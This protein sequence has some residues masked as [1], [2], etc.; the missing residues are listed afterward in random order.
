M[1]CNAGSECKPCSQEFAAGSVPTS[2]YST[3][4]SL[5]PALIAEDEDDTFFPGLA[6]EKEDS[7]SLELGAAPGDVHSSAEDLLSIDSALHGTEYYRDLGFP[8]PLEAGA[9]LGPAASGFP[10][11]EQRPGAPA[12]MSQDP[13]CPARVPCSMAYQEVGCHFLNSDCHCSCAAG[14]A[15]AG[16]VAVPGAGLELQED[17]ESFPTLVRSMSTSRRH[18]WESP[19]SPTESRRRF[20]LDTAEMGSDPEQDEDERS[21]PC[22]L[23]CTALELPATR[24]RLEA[25]SRAAMEVEMKP[26]CLDLPVGLGYQDAE[27]GSNRKRLRSKSIPSTCEGV[28]PPRLSRDLEAL[29]P[30]AEGIQPPVLETMEEDHVSP[31]RVLIVQQVLQEQKQYHGAKQWAPEGSDEPQQN[32]TWFE[33]LSNE[34]EDSGKSDKV[35]K[36]TTVMRRL[37]S[38]RS[39]V[40]GSWQK[41]KGKNKEQQ[42]RE[43]EKEKEKEEKEKEKEL[44]GTWKVNGHQL[45]LGVFSSSTSCSLCAK[46][47]G[48]KT[49]L[50]CRREYG[51]PPPPPNNRLAPPHLLTVSP[52]LAAPSDLTWPGSPPPNHLT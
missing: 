20:S 48:N 11:A 27:C 31:D 15:G 30:A 34:N 22:S 36:G 42:Q 35:E 47:L 13:T 21:L 6:E 5:S 45:V 46:P 18:S 23:P 33:F 43:K 52:G 29:L 12:A 28:P 16:S 38:L 44:Q 26:L 40:T 41:D 19:L 17:E 50:Q 14:A 4:D 7:S 8:A 1:R 24:G 39:R 49:G 2:S 3:P 10:A 32:L 51:C 25:G 9:A 37:S